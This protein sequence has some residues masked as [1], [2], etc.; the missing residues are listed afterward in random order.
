MKLAKI[1][2]HDNGSAGYMECPHFGNVSLPNRK[3]R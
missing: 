2:K 3:E 1:R